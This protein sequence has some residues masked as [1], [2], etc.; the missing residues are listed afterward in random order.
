[1]E[2]V[3]TV[4]PEELEI[5][6]SDRFVVAATATAIDQFAALSGDCNPLHTDAGY[7]REAGFKGR[8]AHG[9]LQQAFISRMAGTCLPGK[10]CF[11]KKVST[12]YLSPVFE[13]EALLVEGAVTRLDHGHESG[14]LEV[15]ITAERSREV[16]SIS[17]VE[18]GLI[19]VRTG[20]AAVNGEQDAGKFY[21]AEKA[22]GDA[23]APAVLL[24]GGTGGLG[25][26]IGR[27]LA[28][29]GMRCFSAG[30][31]G[32]CDLTIDFA[33]DDLG[34]LV[35]FCAQQRMTAV[36]HLASP[37]P[38]K[39]VPSELDLPH[40]LLSLKTQLS[41]LRELAAAIRKDRLPDLRDIVCIGSA[42]ARHRF[43][44]KGFEGYAYAKTLLWY[45]AADC[46]RDLAPRGVRINTIAPSE[47]TIGMNAGMADR[48]RALL[49]SKLP[50]GKMTDPEDVAAAVAGILNSTV[51]MTGQEIVMAGGRTW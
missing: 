26:V 3:K 47:L 22:G 48:T 18:F 23:A 44:E 40:L 31:S 15:R 11:I 42:W 35:A 51:F 1:M 50:S 43:P 32:R 8:V 14:L 9:A 12:S 13:G 7:A 5:G 4:R 17:H 41:P 2:P 45:Y 46:A 16:K 34:K 30:R 49:A 6:M 27:T 38:H 24:L 37:G 21:K 33:G 20:P 19:G 25:T 36:V 39:A 29:R 10:F 28:G